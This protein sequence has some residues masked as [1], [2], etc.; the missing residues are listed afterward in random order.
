MIAQ[1][2]VQDYNM[3]KCSFASVIPH[4]SE[5][6]SQNRTLTLMGSPTRLDV[7]ELDSS[8]GEIDLSRLSR[9]TSPARKFRL[10][11]V[12]VGEGRQ[13]QSEEFDCGVGGML[14]TFE[15]ACSEDGVQECSIDFYQ[16][17]PETQ[18]RMGEE[19]FACLLGSADNLTIAFRVARCPVPFGVIASAISDPTPVAYERSSR[20]SGC[21]P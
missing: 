15:F 12:T 11:S 8:E 2:R 14:R 7:W 6:L 10:S 4:R 13:T 5:L 1:I 21:V 17:Q 20:P 9:R 18:P 16:E 3:G 19:H